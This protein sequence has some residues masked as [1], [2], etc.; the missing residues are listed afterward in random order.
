MLTEFG[1]LPICMEL[2]F[3]S[4]DGPPHWVARLRRTSGWLLV[5]E[6]TIQSEHDILTERLV[7]A[8][9]ELENPIPSFKA[10]NLLNCEWLNPTC[11]DELPPDL[12]EDLIC[13]EEGALISRWHREKNSALA[14]AFETSEKRI[15]ELE[16]RVQF[17][18]ARNEARIAELRQRRRHFDATPAMRQAMAEVIRELDAENDELLA[19]M[20]TT[21]AAIR[22]QS[23]AFE[24]TLWAR[25]DLLFEVTPL[26]LVRWRART[27]AYSDA[28]A[29][30]KQYATLWIPA[31]GPTEN[32]KS[33]FKNVKEEL[34]AGLVKTAASQADKGPR[35]DKGVKPPI[36]KP[37]HPKPLSALPK[38]SP[39]MRKM[40]EASTVGIG[41]DIERNNQPITVEHKENSKSE[42]DNI[43]PNQPSISRE[44]GSYNRFDSSRI[45][46]T[47]AIETKRLRQRVQRIRKA[48]SLKDKEVDDNILDRHCIAILRADLSILENR[49]KGSHRGDR[50]DIVSAARRS[51][52]EILLGELGA[53]QP[54]NY[55]SMS[56]ASRSVEQDE[57]QAR[58]PIDGSAVAS[59]RASISREPTSA[60]AAVQNALSALSAARK[61]YY[62]KN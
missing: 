56:L 16:G 37:D 46:R 58:L 36:S 47:C 2:D 35:A 18:I 54:A 29:R 25:D 61:R 59:T 7:V 53:D 39:A 41:G 12:L 15:A 20:A 17:T 6:A 10:A 30:S 49:Y 28:P 57:V 19:E 9:D 33:R 11:C 14:E 13:E 5:A 22:S 32:T 40:A 8:C 43:L 62:G 1:V 44:G 60:P 48:K 38:H 21:R 42:V 34:A 45:D 51:A 3:D 31:C 52:I 23:S 26:H 4:F 55:Q 50:V 24:E 27:K